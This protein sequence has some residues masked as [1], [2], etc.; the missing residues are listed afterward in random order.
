M[1]KKGTRGGGEK[2]KARGINR[3]RGKKRD[4]PKK[5][6]ESLSWQEELKKPWKEK[7][8]QRIEGATDEESLRKRRE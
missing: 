1:K 2:K 3:L 5:C 6:H 7:E 4:L 8:S